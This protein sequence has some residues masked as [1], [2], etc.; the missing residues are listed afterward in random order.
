M[1]MNKCQTP[2]NTKSKI[3]RREIFTYPMTGESK[4]A[5]V[6]KL[7]SLHTRIAKPENTFCNFETLINKGR[8]S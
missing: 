1:K 7:V 6:I 5:Q 8:K 2:G 3:C 4:D